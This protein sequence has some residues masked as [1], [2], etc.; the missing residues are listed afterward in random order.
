MLWS[1]V[2]GDALMEPFWPLGTGANR[3]VLSAWDC[4]ASL[5]QV[6]MMGLL[7]VDSPNIGEVGAVA[8]AAFAMYQ[9]LQATEPNTMKPEKF[10]MPNDPTPLFSFDPSSRYPRI[11]AI[12]LPDGE[13][14]V[15]EWSAFTPGTSKVINTLSK[16]DSTDKKRHSNP[17]MPKVGG[18]AAANE[19]AS[20]P[21]LVKR[22][23]TAKVLVKVAKDGSRTTLGKASMAAKV[24][25]A[26]TTPPAASRASAPVGSAPV[27]PAAGPDLSRESMAPPASSAPVAPPVSS[28]PTVVAPSP[29]RVRSQGPC[30]ATEATNRE[31]N[32]S[33]KTALAAVAANEPSFDIVD[34]SGNTIFQMKHREMCRELSAALRN[35][36]YVREVH[37][38]QCDVDKVDVVEL[39]GAL[40][41]NT[42]V[43]V[44]DLEKCKVREAVFV[45]VFVSHHTLQSRYRLTTTAPPSWPT[46]CASTAPSVRSI[47][48]TSP[49]KRS[50]TPA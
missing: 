3:A 2:L 50:A 30:T 22:G 4:C 29:A 39:M 34:L 10:R 17:F 11:K 8:E 5:V 47:C 42:T 20:S 12:P 41:A 49:Q 23:S 18:G 27:P 1:F 32:K 36:C 6:G 15:I 48:S 14:N 35:N 25:P 37:L 28:A 33:P 26:K 38:K 31:F 7:H 13:G 16:A 45:C 9:A 46:G 24:V 19:L 21:V 40:A 44:L 43:T